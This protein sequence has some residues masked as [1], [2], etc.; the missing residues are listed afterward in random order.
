MC[1][2]NRAWFFTDGAYQPR[3]ALGDATVGGILILPGMRVQVFGARVPPELAQKWTNAGKEHV[4][5][6]PG[7]NV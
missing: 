1:H 3:H 6:V 5:D 4:L 7:I 2:R